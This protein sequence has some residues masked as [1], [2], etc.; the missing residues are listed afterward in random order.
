VSGNACYNLIGEPG[1]IRQCIE[2]M[3]ALPV[4]DSAKAKIIVGRTARTKCNDDGLALLYLEIAT[5]HDVVN[6]LK[7]A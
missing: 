2:T 1:V 3:A 7:Q 4:S 6:R 5:N